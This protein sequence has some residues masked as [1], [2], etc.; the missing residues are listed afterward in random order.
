MEHCMQGAHVFHT[1]VNRIG[2]DYYGSEHYS[3]KYC[4]FPCASMGNPN[5][6]GNANTPRDSI[7]D[8]IDYEW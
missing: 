2:A 8:K 1:A 7:L 3:Q 4:H 5:D 6:K